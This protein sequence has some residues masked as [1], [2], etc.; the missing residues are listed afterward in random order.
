MTHYP[1]SN[2]LPPSLFAAAHA[3]KAKR[4]AVLARVRA[5][6][7][8]KYKKTVAEWVAVGAI[9]RGSTLKERYQNSSR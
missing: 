1:T 6:R 9:F 3:A 2:Q 4:R 8:K 5:Q 7:A